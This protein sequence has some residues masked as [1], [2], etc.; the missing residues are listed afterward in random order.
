MIFLLISNFS[1]IQNFNHFSYAIYISSTQYNSCNCSLTRINISINSSNNYTTQPWNTQIIFTYT[2][3]HF[4]Q[5]NKHLAK[6]KSPGMPCIRLPRLV[7]TIQTPYRLCY[8]LCLSE[9]LLSE[10]AS[11]RLFLFIIFS[12]QNFRYHSGIKGMGYHYFVFFHI[13]LHV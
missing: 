4:Q 3:C 7:T 9:F 6:R 8:F 2:E 10:T 12:F 11:S 5:Q 1:F 13:L